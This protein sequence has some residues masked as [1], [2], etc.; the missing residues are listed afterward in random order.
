MLGC[1][2]L[3]EEEEMPRESFLLNY[4]VDFPKFPRIEVDPL[5]FFFVLY[6]F[7]ILFLPVIRWPYR[8]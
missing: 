1:K 5:V 3:I 7:S 2:G 4:S 8:R 6:F